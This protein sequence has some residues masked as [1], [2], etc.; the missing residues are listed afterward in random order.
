MEKIIFKFTFYPL[1]HFKKNLCNLLLQMNCKNQSFNQID[2]VLIF[3]Y[4]YKFKWLK[5]EQD[6]EQVERTEAKL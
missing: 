1:L 3:A 6:R 2:F 4:R 5:V